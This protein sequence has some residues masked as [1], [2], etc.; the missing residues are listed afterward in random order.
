MCRSPLHDPCPHQFYHRV[1]LKLFRMYFDLVS[2]GACGFVLLNLFLFLGPFVMCVLALNLVTL[3]SPGGIARV[4]CEVQCWFPLVELALLA[5]ELFALPDSFLIGSL[6]AISVAD[7]SG[8][9]R[10]PNSIR[11][12]SE[13]ACQVPRVRP[14]VSNHVRSAAVGLTVPVGHHRCFQSKQ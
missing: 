8:F 3:L 2:S 14:V 11:V 10:S 6:A 4:Q 5:S 9:R 12:T 1:V 13:F 7:L